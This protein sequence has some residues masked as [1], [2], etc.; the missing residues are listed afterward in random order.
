[1]DK[2]QLNNALM[3]TMAL[4]QQIQVVPVGSYQTQYNTYDPND[5]IAMRKA[6]QERNK[7]SSW[8]ALS[9]AL[10]SVQPKSYT[11][12][13]GVE[14]SN[15]WVS[16]IASALQGFD[17][18]YTARKDAERQLAND[19]FELAKMMAEANKKAITE[20]VSE[21]AIKRNVKDDVVEQARTAQLLG[22]MEGDLEDIGARFDDDYAN[23]DEM[24]KNITRLGILSTDALWG[25]GRSTG[26]KLAREQFEAWKGSMKNVLVNANRQ[27]GTGAMSDADAARFEQNLGDARNPAEARNILDSFKAR[28]SMTPLNKRE[29]VL[30]NGVV[31]QQNKMQQIQ[32]EEDILM[33]QIKSMMGA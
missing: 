1:M 17:K 10:G 23:I 28:M 5:I 25:A 33:Q 19:E 13:Y 18:A 27:A 20:Q 11:G 4:P 14:V 2:T 9:N 6:I 24:Q 29:D 3:P 26:E 32:D 12:A 21:Q 31:N 22:V 8:E 15:P 7:K 16:G 30:N